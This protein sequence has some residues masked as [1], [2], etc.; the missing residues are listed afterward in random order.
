MKQLLLLII[1]TI[2]AGH[3]AA[4]SKYIEAV[5]EYVPAPGQF[6]NTL[7]EATADDTP[8]TMARKCTEALAGG[9]GG[10][11]TLG[12]WGGYVVFHFDHPVVNIDGERDFAVWGNAFD[13]AAEPAI[14]MVA[15]D[16][17]GNH[18]PDDPWYE[19]RGSEYDNPLTIHDYGLT[20]SYAPLKDVSWTDNQGHEGSVPRNTF[21]AQEYFP[22]WLAAEG[23]LSFSGARLPDNAELVGKKYLLEAFSYGYADNQP[24]D[25]V[26][27]CSMDIGWAVDAQG[28]PVS[29]SHIDFVK[30]YNAMNQ[31]CGNI[32]ETST[33][34][35][36]AEDLHLEASMAYA[37]GIMN[38]E[39]SKLN[40]EDYYNL[41]GR[42]VKHP[43]KGLY[44]KN[45]KKT[46]IN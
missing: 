24:N 39:N 46:I 36:G 12:A 7:P 34:I 32:G 31:V 30:C 1:A 44:I 21:H 42:R 28:R 20:Y 25:N 38:I 14:V 22:L 8:A 33:E 2:A 26:E 3:A 19:L 5:D 13:Y 40:I 4:Q 41:W 11:I 45:G 29:L 9:A 15:V 10:M 27:G 6:V 37:A 23:Q 43:G 16:A 18:L 17:N 35:T